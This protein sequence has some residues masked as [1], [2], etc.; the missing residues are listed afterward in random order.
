V[1]NDEIRMTKPEGISKHQ[2]LS[3]AVPSVVVLEVFV[4]FAIR[5]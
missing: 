4:L 5:H 3:N 2:G 1:R